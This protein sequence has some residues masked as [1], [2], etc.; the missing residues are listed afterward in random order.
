MK[1][2]TLEISQGGVTLVSQLVGE[3]P[4]VLRIIEEDS[5]RLE[6]SLAAPKTIP[7]AYQYER[8]PDDDFTMPVPLHSPSQ[9]VPQ[10]EPVSQLHNLADAVEVEIEPDFDSFLE[11][12]A[13]PSMEIVLPEAD[14]VGIEPDFVPASEEKSKVD[15]PTIEF[16]SVPEPKYSQADVLHLLRESI[17]GTN[18]ELP[19]DLPDI[20]EFEAVELSIWRKGVEQW[21]LIDKIRPEG[22]YLF[23]GV[24]VWMDISGSL[25][26]SGGNQALVLVQEM[27]GAE[28]EHT[29]NGGSLQL[30]SGAIVVIQVENELICIRPD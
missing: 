9:K 23:H 13:S 27:N 10:K 26:L 7:A 5:V 18:V 28:Q 2:F 29:M 24:H 12:D 20:P 1:K 16:I 4:F 17:N 21:D 15:S 11:L 6:M 14:L 3:E 19:P 30:E 8:S 22:E 25:L